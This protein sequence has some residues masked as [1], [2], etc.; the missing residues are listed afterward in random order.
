TF[1]DPAAFAL[2]RAVGDLCAHFGVASLAPFGVSDMTVGLQAAGAALAYVRATQG[3]ALGHLTRLA[4]LASDEAMILDPT[5][6]QT[7]ELIDTRDGDP[8][9]TLFGILDETTTPMGAR[10]LRQWLLRPLLDLGAI[11][12]RQDA[13]QALIDDPAARAELR[14]LFKHVGD[15]ER[16]T[17]RATLGT[18]HDPGL[19][20]L[21]A[22]LA[23]LGDIRAHLGDVTAPLVTTARDE[24]APL[25]GLLALLQQALVDEPP[26][27]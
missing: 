27:V 11:A 15:L 7:L 5:A 3:E 17:S 10:L 23:P 9:M 19:V 21:R 20:A 6:V 4:R 8:R 22:C 16:L 26:L 25:D 13:V 1:W 12:A 18:P 24:I 14:R 2:R